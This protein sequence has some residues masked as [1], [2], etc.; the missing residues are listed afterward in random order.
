MKYIGK[1]NEY[2]KKQF[3]LVV[4]IYTIYII[5]FS[6]VYILFIIV[7]ERDILKSIALYKRVAI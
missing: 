7:L 3:N 6:I 2:T 1:K 5:S 4:G